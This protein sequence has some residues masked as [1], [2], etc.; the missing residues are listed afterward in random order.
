[1]NGNEMH[2]AAY[3]RHLAAGN[4][5]PRTLQNYRETL[6]QLAR[7]ANTDDITTLGRVEIEEYISA[8]LAAPKRRR[9]N[10]HHQNSTAAVRFRALRAFFNWAVDEEII[11]VSPMR[12]MK[13]PKVTDAPVPVLRDDQLIA[14][15]KSCEGTSF[16]A[17]RD[18]ALIRLWCEPGSPR[19]AEMAGLR[20]DDVEL[21]QGMVTVCGKGSKIRVIPYGAK[22]GQAI[23]R[24]LRVR[25][26]HR[27]AASPEL[28]LAARRGISLT[29]SGMEQMLR[30]RGEQAGIGPIHPHQLRHS[31]AHNFA[32]AGGNEGDAM[33]LFGWSSSE[34]PRR[35]GASARVERAHRAARRISP[36]DRF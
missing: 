24:Y 9:G 14:L 12:K 34:M 10:G 36:A 35:Y 26:R 11:D 19:V 4:R 1:V 33:V 18:M 23:D 31:S 13:E 3:E 29:A 22:T 16:E 5:S 20:L 2:L 17:R 28:W 15:I 8:V 30:R 6:E 27:D 7:H 21:R 25:S 32:L